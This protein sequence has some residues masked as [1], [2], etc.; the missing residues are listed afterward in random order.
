MLQRERGIFFVFGGKIKEKIKK[1]VASPHGV[2][3]VPDEPPKL[4]SAGCKSPWLLA[5]GNQGL[6]DE[7]G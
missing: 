4:S 6:R 5:I 7:R 1:K 2:S 3:A